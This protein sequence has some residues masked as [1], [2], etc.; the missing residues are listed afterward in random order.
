MKTKTTLN[1]LFSFPGFR[2]QTHL[3]G[4]LGN[5]PARIITLK[6]RQKKL[7]APPV[8]PYT[9]AIT[10]SSST[11]YAIYPPVTL[12]STW[13]SNIAASTAAGAKP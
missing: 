3:K 6:R 2:A 13:S 8:A 7:F 1:T 11:V 4:I 9:T 12:A 10:T 5:S